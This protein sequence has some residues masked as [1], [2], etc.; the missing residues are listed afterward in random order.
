MFLKSRINF[1]FYFFFIANSEN[2]YTRVYTR[3]QCQKLDL[4]VESLKINQ[5][6]LFIKK[7]INKNAFLNDM[8]IMFMTLKLLFY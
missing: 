4:E 7:S 8:V 3:T 1:A 2:N 6:Y 5:S